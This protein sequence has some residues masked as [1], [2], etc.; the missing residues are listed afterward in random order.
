MNAYWGSWRRFADF[1]GRTSRRDYWVACFTGFGVQFLY[2]VFCMVLC[3]VI[4][5]YLEL[6]VDQMSLAFRILTSLY[7]TAYL[8]PYLAMT[9]RRLRDAGYHSKLLFLLIIPPVGFLAI[10]ARLC[11]K[12]VEAEAVSQN[13]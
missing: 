3:L 6:T 8:L 10:L 1:S 4:A 13:I 7:S 12:S 2:S 11:S 9:V 5:A